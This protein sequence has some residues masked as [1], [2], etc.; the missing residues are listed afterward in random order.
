MI[1]EIMR[2][3]I[4]LNLS[5]KL[6]QNEEKIANVESFHEGMGKPQVEVGD[7][8]PDAEDI[9]RDGL[10]KSQRSVKDRVR[11]AVERNTPDDVSMHSSQKLNQLAYKSMNPVIYYLATFVLY[12]ME[13]W[14]SIVVDDIGNIFGF[15]G[16][17]AGTSLSFF[18]P[19]VLFCKAFNMFA[20]KRYK[21]Q[22]RRLFVFSIVNFVLGIG[23]FGLFLY[24][25]ILSLQG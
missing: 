20:S 18:I 4:S 3:S 25:N 16:T 9:A 10:M 2:R 5:K 6:L 15:I 22:N 1:D 17:I 7:L 13:I 14:L 24:S 21:Q 23:F 12:A 8:R 11:K 19:S